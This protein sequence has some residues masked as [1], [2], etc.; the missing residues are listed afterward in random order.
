MAAY[1][2]AL[3]DRSLIPIHPQ[4]GQ[5]SEDG[6]RVFLLRPLLVGILDAE[7]ENPLR[8]SGQEPVEEGRPGSAYVEDNPWERARNGLGG[9][10]LVFIPEGQTGR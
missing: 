3:E 9:S 4:P 7:Y 1:A 8:L 6:L 10:W 5:A 2:L